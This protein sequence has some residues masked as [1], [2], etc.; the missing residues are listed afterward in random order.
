MRGIPSLLFVLM[1]S[2]LMLCGCTEYWAKPGGTEAEFEATE[3]ACVARSYQQFPPMPQMVMVSSGN[4]AS[5]TN[6]KCSSTGSSTNCTS[7][8]GHFSMPS[9][10]VVDINE[11]AR[12]SAVRACLFAAGWVPAKNEAEA[13]AIF[14]A[15][16]QVPGTPHP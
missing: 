2:S 1:L 11:D 5:I 6:T 8:G 7:I 16:P 15:S 12:Y 13:K 14:N 10:T 4:A 3:S 9:V